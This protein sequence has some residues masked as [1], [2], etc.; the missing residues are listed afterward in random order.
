MAAQSLE[1]IRRVAMEAQSKGFDKL[2]ADLDKV[3]KSQEGVAGS[4]TTV[5]KSQGSVDAAFARTERTLD[6]TMV[7]YQ[8]FAKQVQATNNAL[9][10]GRTS[11]ERAAQLIGLADA[12]LQKATGSTAQFAQS[13][14]L[15][16]HELINLGRQL[17]DVVVSLGSGQGLGTVLL[18]QGAQIGDVFASMRGT[19]GAALTQ[20]A[21]MAV[22]VAPVAVALGAV[23]TAIY[24][25]NKAMSE[26]REARIA[27]ASGLGRLSDITA[28]QVPGLAGRAAG[29][30]V[31][32]GD[33]REGVL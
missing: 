1:V 22:R 31:S 33:A 30:G 21:G 2:A 27:T 7:A 6:K 32:M 19:V 29:A 8:A 15:A 17:Q 10:Q 14:G 4:S 16:R 5:T 9:E 3:A 20:L 28:G 18:Q 11:P 13:T 26:Q 24:A 25:V 23:A 12:Q